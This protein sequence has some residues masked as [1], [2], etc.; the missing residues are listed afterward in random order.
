MTG[1]SD[2]PE[3]WLIDPDYGGPYGY[4][5]LIIQQ[6]GFRLACSGPFIPVGKHGDIY[7]SLAEAQAQL[8]EKQPRTMQEAFDVHR[9][10][11]DSERES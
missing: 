6:D 1:E 9:T 5:V 10:P 4:N 2:E 8:I 7:Q 3:E 11:S